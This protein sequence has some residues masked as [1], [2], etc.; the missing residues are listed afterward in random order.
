MLKLPNMDLQKAF[1][2]MKILEWV[3]IWYNQ[4]QPQAAFAAL[5]KSLQYEWSYLQRI[6]PNFDEEYIMILEAMNETF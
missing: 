3:N 2:E 1:V 6:L 4:T 5:A